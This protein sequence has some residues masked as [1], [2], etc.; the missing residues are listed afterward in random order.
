[1]NA[2]CIKSKISCT[3]P[4]KKYLAEI[5]KYK[6]ISTEYVSLCHNTTCNIRGHPFMMSTRKSRPPPPVHMSLAPYP[7]R[8]RT[9]HQHKIQIP[10]LKQLVQLPLSQLLQ[11]NNS[12]AK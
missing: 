2:Q 5:K 12:V 7:F 10:L 11:I 1:M 4:M 6:P 9:C 8:T 3:F